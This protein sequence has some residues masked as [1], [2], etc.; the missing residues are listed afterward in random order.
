MGKK[1]GKKII[2]ASRELQNKVGTGTI[3][4][5]KISAAQKIMDDNKTDF[6][7]L[8]KP[9]LDKLR[10]AI[11]KARE[12]SSNPDAIMKSLKTPIMNL[13]AN[14]GTFNYGFLSKLTGTVLL[15]LED[16]KTPDRKI[17]QIVDVLHKTILLA[18]AYQMRGDGGKNGKVLLHIFE[19]L[20]EKYRPPR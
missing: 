12:D 5:E 16:V 2:K 3:N 6:A 8:A 15:F 13:K 11:E 18:L 9:E 10:K 17:I 14:A 1:L 19:E 7:P 4:E 20:C